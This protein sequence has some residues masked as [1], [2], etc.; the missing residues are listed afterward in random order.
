M[1]LLPT[2]S[3]DHGVPSA[4]WPPSSMST[5]EHQSFEDELRLDTLAATLSNL[6]LR[7]LTD[8]TLGKAA[9]RDVALL[10]P[11]L[12]PGFLQYS[13]GFS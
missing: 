11:E 9:G 1:Y 5:T 8:V 13:S 2:I 7:L 6:F 4:H 3:L 12:L 10:N